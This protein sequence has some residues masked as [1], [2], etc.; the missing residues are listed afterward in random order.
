[1]DDFIIIIIICCRKLCAQSCK[2]NDCEL[3]LYN[4]PISLLISVIVWT[5]SVRYNLVLFLIKY[6][7]YDINFIFFLKGEAVFERGGGGQAFHSL[8]FSIIFC[9]K[10]NFLNSLLF[11]IYE[12]GNCKIRKP[13][14][15]G[16]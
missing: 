13:Q 7:T 6:Y 12:L 3:I 9:G 16:Q 14:G 10:V 2:A 1:M 15:P 4:N 8:F 11:I 5:A